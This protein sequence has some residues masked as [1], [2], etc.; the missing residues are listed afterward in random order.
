MKHRK[1]TIMK[2]DQPDIRFAVTVTDGTRYGSDITQYRKFTAQAFIW[3]RDR[4]AAGHPFDLHSPA[5]YSVDAGPARVLDGLVVTAQADSD[6]MKRPGSEWYAWAVGYDR[7]KT[8]LKDAEEILPVLRKIARRTGKLAGELGQPAT[9]A[10]YCAYAVSA[11]TST[12]DPFMRRVPPGQDISGTG[13]HSMDASGLACFLGSDAAGWR[14]D[15][16][17]GPA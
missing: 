9:L 2:Q 16:G 15:R 4:H 13:Y 8:E 17:I 6:S 12:R 3:A 5:S 10:Q 7:S 1:E 11:V 14:K